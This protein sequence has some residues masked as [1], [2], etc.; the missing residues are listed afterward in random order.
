MIYLVLYDQRGQCQRV[1]RVNSREQASAYI[2]IGFVEVDSDE[3]ERCALIVPEATQAELNNLQ[4]ATALLTRIGSTTA[5]RIIVPASNTQALD[6]LI[7]RQ[8]TKLQ[9]ITDRYLDTRINERQWFRQIVNAINAGNIAASALA[10]G[11]IDNLSQDD[12]QAIERE[13]ER[14]IAYLNRFRRNLS[15]L[16]PAEI[17]NRSGLYAGAITTRYWTA[18]TRAQG[19]VLPA[20][21]GVRTSC[22]SNCKCNWDIRKLSGDGNWDCYWRIS[23]VESCPECLQRQRV[24]NPLQVRNF[25]VQPFNPSGIYR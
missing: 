14:Q 23:A 9:S 21:P 19:L 20:M 3:Y 7:E 25:I 17:R 24:F 11:G 8:R 22:H 18:H 16:S 2:S 10:V 4:T 1:A 13:N 5:Q 15:I 12:Q 6:R